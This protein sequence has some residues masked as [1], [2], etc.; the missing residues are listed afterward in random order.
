M[1]GVIAWTD[2]AFLIIK[3]QSGGGVKMAAS[4]RGLV[5][6]MRKTV[7]DEAMFPPGS[8][9]LVALSGGADS[10][11][12]L[13]ALLSLRETL[14]LR[15]IAATHVNH[16][17]RGEEALR[18]EQFVREQCRSL[19]TPLTVLH[20]DVA[21]EAAARGEGLEAAGRR[22]RYAYFEREAERLGAVVAT[23]HTLNDSVETVLLH[24]ARGCG[25]GGLRGIPASATLPGGARAVRPLI[26]CTR[27]QVE[28]YCAENAI[29]FVTDSTNADPSF[30]RNRVRVQVIPALTAINPSL[31]AAVSRLMKR[32]GQ[33]EAYLRA[34]AADA[35]E[36][37]ALC[38]GRDGWSVSFLAEL[39]PALRSRA[40]ILAVEQKTGRS[41]SDAQIDAL[42]RLLITGG[43]ATLNQDWAA[44]AAQGRFA[45]VPRERAPV[46][47]EIPLQSGISCTFSGRIYMP[48]LLALADFE[49][50]TKIHKNLL[51]N[52]LNYDKIS[53]YV[54]LRS[55]RPGDAFRPAGRGVSKTLKKLMN[56]EKLPVEKRDAVAV[57]CDREGIVLVEGFGCDE[58]V[59]IGPDTHRVL[60]LRENAKGKGRGADGDEG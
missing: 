13:H 58:R 15:L 39:A 6:T 7:A 4:G 57:L 45:L 43:E 53:G 54:S 5:E 10:M 9:V 49:K 25:L 50:E 19:G 23:A 3:K 30:A 33:D 8:A 22:I 37:A 38:D 2:G 1:R 40:L 56:E 26:G 47:R 41:C 28:G 21:A 60:V 24:L 29:R 55:R 14:G 31:P 44:R 20:A 46:G 11:A 48:E 59:R 35:L 27:A 18:D 12:L 34:Q 36:C 42:E 16:G 32:A 17:L 52:A 51:K